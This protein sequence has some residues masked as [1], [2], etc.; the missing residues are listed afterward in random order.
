MSSLTDDRLQILANNVLEIKHVSIFNIN[1]TLTKLR[2]YPHSFWSPVKV[3]MFSTI[4]I[5]IVAI[6]I[7]LSIG[8]VLQMFLKME[9]VVY[10]H[11]LD[12]PP[13]QS[14]IPALNKN[15]FWTI[16]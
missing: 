12:Q 4:C 8:F 1:S 15:Y 10:I 7:T 3:K 14:K 6:S 5:P 16:A 2:T 11:T 13:Y 9:R